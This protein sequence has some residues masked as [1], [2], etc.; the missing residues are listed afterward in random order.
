M[1][2]RNNEPALKIYDKLLE[3]F[4]YPPRG[5]GATAGDAPVGWLWL[6]AGL[7]EG[8]GLRGEAGFIDPLSNASRESRPVKS[9]EGLS[10]YS[11]GEGPM[12]RRAAQDKNKHWSTYHT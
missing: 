5:D 7:G 3:K 8:P 4:S 12:Q 11:K 1:G 9:Y 10:E 2:F 6:G